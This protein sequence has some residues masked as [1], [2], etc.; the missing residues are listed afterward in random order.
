MHR[1]PQA[2]YRFPVA[3]TDPSGAPTP[4]EIVG[5]SLIIA[6]SGEMITE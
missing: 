4:E 6:V 1:I 3:A 5:F 2:P